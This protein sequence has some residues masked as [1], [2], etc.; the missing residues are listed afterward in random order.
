M[1]QN[2]LD[3]HYSRFNSQSNENHAFFFHHG[4]REFPFWE[5]PLTIM[6][7]KIQSFHCFWPS[8]DYGFLWLHCPKLWSEEQL[9]GSSSRLKITAITSRKRKL[10]HPCC[11]KTKSRACMLPISH[12]SIFNVIRNISISLMPPGPRRGAEFKVQLMHWQ[13]GE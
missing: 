4:V 8:L 12:I 7:L 9:F 1:M 10:V 3:R 13:V 2:P 11:H 5:M 6:P